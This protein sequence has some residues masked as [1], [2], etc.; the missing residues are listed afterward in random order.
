M[1]PKIDPEKVLIV[2]SNHRTLIGI[3]DLDWFSKGYHFDLLF[4]GYT[5]VPVEVQSTFKLDS[6]EDYHDILNNMKRRRKET[7]QNILRCLSKANEVLERVKDLKALK[8]V[9]TKKKALYYIEKHKYQKEI[10][11][12]G[13]KGINKV[14]WNMQ[15][16][17]AE[18]ESLAFKKRLG[19]IIQELSALVKKTSEKDK[20]KDLKARLNKAQSEQALTLVHRQL[21]RNFGF[22]SE[23]RDLFGSQLRNFTAPAG[24]YRVTLTIAGKTVEGKLCIRDD[25]LLKN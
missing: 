6:L 19:K 21:T 7:I 1:I 25:T 18:E 17:P 22:Y 15:F 3:T 8:V 23:G 14:R 12:S 4:T 20:L 2:A 10:T 9:K 16:S 24:E 5:S 11:L 13:K